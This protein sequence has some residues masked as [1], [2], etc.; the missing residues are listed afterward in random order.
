MDARLTPVRA[1]PLSVADPARGKLILIMSVDIGDGRQGK[2]HVHRLDEPQQLA[3]RHVAE[4][5]GHRA[6]PAGD[7]DEPRLWL[8]GATLASRG[9]ASLANAA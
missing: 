4:Q 8:G 1:P 2:I 3:A 9:G 7:R 5:A 6:E